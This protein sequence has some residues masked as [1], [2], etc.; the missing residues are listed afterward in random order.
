MDL[1]RSPQRSQCQGFRIAWLSIEW[2]CLWTLLRI[3]HPCVP[4][5]S[6]SIY[7]VWM[8]G[9]WNKLTQATCIC[10]SSACNLDKTQD[11][12]YVWMILM[13]LNHF[14]RTLGFSLF[15]G[16]VNLYR[17]SCSQIPFD[18]CTCNVVSCLWSGFRSVFPGKHHVFG[19][20]VAYMA[21]KCW[22]DIHLSYLLY[23]L[24]SSLS[25]NLS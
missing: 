16:W 12:W 6:M 1:T 23:L 19:H 13:Y 25:G 5:L 11:V 7:A 17:I 9:P 18:F 24:F 15:S 21:E 10:I 4:R 2:R 8:C 14:T 20:L 22:K 3:Y